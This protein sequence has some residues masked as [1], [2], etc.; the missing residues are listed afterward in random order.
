MAVYDL[1]FQLRATVEEILEL[2]YAQFIDWQEYFSRRPPGWQDDYRAS[3]QL[4]AWGVKDAMSM[5]PSLE[6]VVADSKPTPR[7][8][9]A[10]SKQ[11]VGGNNL[12]QKL[13]AENPGLLP[14][15]DDPNASAD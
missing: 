7:K 9:G 14:F 6:A 1:A 5:Y 10:M 12:L 15:M 4:S 11:Q 13:R 8:D 3:L 2:P